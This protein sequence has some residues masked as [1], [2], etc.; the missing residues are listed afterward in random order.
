MTLRIRLFSLI[1]L[2]LISV[3]AWAGPPVS[4]RKS[5]LSGLN[6]ISWNPPS[7]PSGR[8]VWN[9]TTAPFKS[10]WQATKSATKTTVDLFTPPPPE[11]KIETM[12]D[13]LSL[14]RPE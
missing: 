12:N 5:W 2:L 4:G 9:A 3:S 8:R 6:P 7:I 13:F 11:K 14:P 10:A 1:V